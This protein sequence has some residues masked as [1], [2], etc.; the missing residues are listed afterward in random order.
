MSSTH[1]IELTNRNRNDVE[2]FSESS[3]SPIA[4]LSLS[5]EI[6]QNDLQ[7]EQEVDDE[8]NYPDGGLKAYSVIVGS[9]LG[10]IVNLGIINSIGAIQAYVSTHQ[11]A[12][13]KASSISWIFSIFLSL[14]YALGLVVGP[15]FDRKG[16]LEL[17]IASTCFVFVG[18][19]SSAN[20]TKVYHFILSFICLGIGNGLGM[21][22]LIGVISHWF[23]KK[24]GNYTG[25]ATSG[26]SVGG[27][28]FPLMLRYTYSV[29]GYVWA[30]RI[31]AFTCL[32]CMLISIL[33]VKGR[34]KRES[35]NTSDEFDTKWDK[36]TS[37][38]KKLSY[39]K[40][41]DAKYIYLIAGAFFAELSLVLVLT[42]FA[43]YAI[44]HGVSE[45]NSL[46]LLTVWNAAGILG[47]WVPGYISDHI[48]RFNVNIL[49]L[50]FYSICILILWLPFG[51][52][53]KI[54]LVFATMAGFSSGSILSLLP[55]C[56][57]Q[58][59]PV[60]EIG[61]K[62]GLLNAILSIG[63]L[64]GVPIASAIIGQGSTTNYNH[65]VIFVGTL[66]V[67]GT[68]FWTLSRVSIVGTKLN[69]KV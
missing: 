42:Y 9:F 30:M 43:T 24:R 14:A 64:F 20:S 8:V 12:L 40:L 67:I 17:L 53:Y 13:V 51:S 66:A 47:R 50:T 29:Y 10:L 61:S 45:S 1:S 37:R 18:L 59:T 62:Y 22:P 27:L 34:F 35:H 49:M 4:T 15:I 2:S 33:L 32:G 21:T 58:I 25:I 23:L 36:M 39:W 16:P 57:S 52:S 28:V 19:M 63:N 11:L 44:S 56:L 26:G 5:N 7:A 38:L 6:G 69:V 41:N 54:L 68:S 31:F 3:D 46:L 48:G 55:A 65:F 60:S